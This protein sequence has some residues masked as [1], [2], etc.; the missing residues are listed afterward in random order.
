MRAAVLNGDKIEIK[1]IEQP[2]L[3]GKGAIVK[4]RGCG[5]CGSDIVKLKHHSVA[6]GT[7]L[8]HEITMSTL[9]LDFLLPKKFN[10]EFYNSQ[11][12]IENPIMIH[13]GLIG[14]YERFLSILL[15]QT[16][17]NL[18]FWLAP[19]Q[20][21]IIPVAEEH[22]AFADE[23]YT[24]LKDNHFYVEVDDRNERIS[25]KIRESQINKTKIQIVIGD[26][27]IATNELS[28]RF[29][30]QKDIIKIKKIELIDYLIKLRN[31]KK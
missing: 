30:G 9:Q 15:E 20:V 31:E 19:K 29:Y 28:L 23:I 14:T 12:S 16:K 21:I 22:K 3:V 18:P 27:E 2:K 13:R 11:N 1:E 7:V 24:Q 17:G 4:V 10:L 25:K 5:L 26:D 6:D 8:G